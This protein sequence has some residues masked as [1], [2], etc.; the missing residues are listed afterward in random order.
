M[1]REIAALTP[2]ELDDLCD[3]LVAAVDDGASIGFLPPMH[4]SEAE[5]YWRGVTKPGTVLLVW[6]EDGTILG[7][8]QLHL[9]GR[10]NGNHRGEVAKLIVH[11]KARRRGIARKLMERL[12]EIAVERERRLLVL[13]TREGDPSNDLYRSMGYQEAGRIPG[14]A[15]SGSGT[16]DTT[17]VYFKPVTSAP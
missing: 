12:H 6:E 3:V 2:R 16:F 14:Y 11:P 13:D 10:P 15:K 4:R 1:I 17:V 7:T 5:A 8:V 9:E